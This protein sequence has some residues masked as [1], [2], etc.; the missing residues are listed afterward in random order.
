MS[1][2]SWISR[3]IAYLLFLERKLSFLWPEGL[4]L[5]RL[6]PACQSLVCYSAW[7]LPL[8][9]WPLHLHTPPCNFTQS[10]GFS[11]HLFAGGCQIPISSLVLLTH[12]ISLFQL[13]IPHLT[14]DVNN[15][16]KSSLF[17][18]LRL[19]H[20]PVILIPVSI[21]TIWSFSSQKLSCH[22]CFCSAFTRHTYP[23]RKSCWVCLWNIL[24]LVCF[25]LPFL[26][27]P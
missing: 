26:S 4:L 11:D 1:P 25:Y 13:R 22:P 17:S 10:R 3:I 14:L 16:L 24:D 19:S 12:L 20:S 15:H 6:A 21:P 18:I 23:L 7:G 8:G 27:P 2:L 9:S 5:P